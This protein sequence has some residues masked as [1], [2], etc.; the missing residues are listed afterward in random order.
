MSGPRQFG[1]QVQVMDLPG[2]GA[3][4]LHVAGGA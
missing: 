3:G 1:T 4:A 2:T